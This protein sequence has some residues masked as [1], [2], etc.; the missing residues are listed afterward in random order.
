MLFVVEEDERMGRELP[1]SG[2][3][4]EAGAMWP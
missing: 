1:F 4:K 3:P 2:N